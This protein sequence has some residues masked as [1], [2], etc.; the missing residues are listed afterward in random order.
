VELTDTQAFDFLKDEW[1]RLWTTKAS[2]EQ[3]AITLITTSGALVTVAFGFSAAV[4][5]NAKFTNFTSA[6]RAVLVAA[7]VLFAISAVVAL[8]VNQPKAYEVPDFSDVLG[9]RTVEAAPS[10]IER[11]ESVLTEG[12]ELNNAKALWLTI[13]F[14]VQ[15]AAIVSLIVAVALVTTA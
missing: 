12:E 9:I 1:Q 10:A 13:A 5:K 11:F 4:T 3:R 14:S 2:L 7:L 8:W 6:E 15:L